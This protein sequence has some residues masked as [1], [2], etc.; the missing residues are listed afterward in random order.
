MSRYEYRVVDCGEFTI[1]SVTRPDFRVVL[2]VDGKWDN[3]VGSGWSEE[4]A[5]QLLRYL[6]SAEVSA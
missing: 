3:D 1:N 2:F 5:T 4:K 6:S